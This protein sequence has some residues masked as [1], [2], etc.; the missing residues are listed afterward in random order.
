MDISVP[1]SVRGR[2]NIAPLEC[3]VQPVSCLGDVDDTKS[4]HEHELV[5]WTSGPVRFAVPGSCP[6]RLNRSLQHF[7]VCSL[8]CSSGDV[9][10]IDSTPVP[11][12]AQL[13]ALIR[14]R[15]LPRHYDTRDKQ[16]VGEGKHV[17]TE[18]RTLYQNQIVNIRHLTPST[19]DLATLSIHAQYLSA[20]PT[21]HVVC[22]HSTRK[23]VKYLD[24][25]LVGRKA[26]GPYAP[27]PIKVS[28]KNVTYKPSHT[29]AV[30]VVAVINWKPLP[31]TFY[32]HVIVLRDVHVITV[33]NT[34]RR[35][36]EITCYCRTVTRTRDSSTRCACDHCKRHGAAHCRNHLLLS[37][38]DSYLPFCELYPPFIGLCGG[39]AIGRR[40]QREGAEVKFS[41]GIEGDCHS[42]ACGRT[43][44]T[45][46][47]PTLGTSY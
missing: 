10:D 19:I 28:C 9:L 33:S 45:G 16:G 14:S 13:F 34:M 21:P 41:L 38:C 18:A 24:C 2:V 4:E 3:R 35:T 25:L 26:L 39:E 31:G 43:N 5:P 32:V 1:L 8:L 15:G 37:H 20:R 17:R 44:R 36:A 7:P 40:G 23:G 11:C 12:L 22:R 27:A 42:H 29:T 47:S 30:R 46:S 6:V